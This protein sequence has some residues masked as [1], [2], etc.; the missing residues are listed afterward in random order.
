[1][2]RRSVIRNMI[3]VSAGAS[4]L[5]AC[6]H[7]EKAATF[8]LKNL[9]LAGAQQDMLADL[10]ATILPVTGNFIGAKDLKAHKFVLTMVD[11]CLNPADQKKFADGLA[12]FEK[13]NGDKFGGNFISNTAKQKNE[14]L[15]ALE[16]KKDIPEDVAN[17]YS[18]VK[19]YTVQCF[20]SSKNFMTDIRHYKMVPGSRFKGCVPVK[21]A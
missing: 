7:N 3:L 2:N 15:T 11:D 12:S 10:S 21:N 14:L 19:H 8:P 16:A 9:T 13:F 17:F 5:P 18:T 1:M 4:I 6:L 20:T